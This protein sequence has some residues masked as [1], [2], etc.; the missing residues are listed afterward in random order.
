MYPEQEALICAVL[1]DALMHIGVEDEVLPTLTPAGWIAGAFGGSQVVRDALAAE[2]RNTLRTRL[3]EAIMLM[4][5]ERK[6]K[7]L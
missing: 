5:A 1:E 6:R 3:R 2:E 7:T 4:T